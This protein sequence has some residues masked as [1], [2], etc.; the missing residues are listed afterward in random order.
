MGIKQYSVAHRLPKNE[1]V[2][3]RRLA[4]TAYIDTVFADSSVQSYFVF[5]TTSYDVVIDKV[6]N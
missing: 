5:I 4:E 1:S 2:T 3:I 6:K